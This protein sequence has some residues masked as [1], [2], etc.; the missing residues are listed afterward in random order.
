MRTYRFSRRD[1][2]A[3]VESYSAGIDVFPL[4]PDGTPAV[5]IEAKSPA[6]NMSVF[7]QRCQLEWV[8][9]TLTFFFLACVQTRSAFQ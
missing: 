6:D 1:F 5:H 9:F 4:H 3:A 7:E 8:F 2:A